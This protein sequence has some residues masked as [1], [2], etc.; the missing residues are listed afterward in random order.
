MSKINVLVLSPYDGGSHA[1]WTAGLQRYSK[2]HTGVLRLPARYWKWRMHGGAVTL[3]RQ[4]WAQRHQPDVLLATDM[5]DLTTFL[6]LTRPLTAHVPAILYMHENQLTYPLPADGRT[7]PMRRQKGERDLHYAF[8]NYASMLAADLVLFNSAY[9]RES[10][11]AELP[12]FLRHYPE[13]NELETIESLQRKS[14]V[15]PVGVEF[16]RLLPPAPPSPRRK[17]SPALQHLF[18]DPQHQRAPFHQGLVVRRPIAHPILCFACALLRP[19]FR[20]RCPFV[21]G[22][23]PE[24]TSAAFIQQRHCELRIA[25]CELR[26]ANCGLR[27]VRYL[28]ARGGSADVYQAARRAIARAVSNPRAGRSHPLVAGTG[29]ALR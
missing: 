4:F 19:L 14:R 24:L 12:R 20:L 28:P 10:L 3:A 26:I 2:H 7:G 5:L 17:R 23:A 13:Y 9:H 16:A 15:L 18:A 11:L 6:A 27:N 25:D 21:F 1:A 8:I 22:H 29:G